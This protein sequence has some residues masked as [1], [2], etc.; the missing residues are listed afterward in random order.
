MWGRRWIPRIIPRDGT[1]EYK[2]FTYNPEY[3]PL[4]P[5]LRNNPHRIT[6]PFVVAMYH[7]VTVEGTCPRSA[8]H[9]GI[10]NASNNLL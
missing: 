4:V 6:T 9:H 3:I 5:S 1:V 7:C 10:G 8:F 2:G